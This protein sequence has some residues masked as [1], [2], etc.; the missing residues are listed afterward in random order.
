MQ[1]LD[2][3]YNS[4]YVNDMGQ[5]RDHPLNIKIIK[6]C[7][8]RQKYRRIKQGKK[9]NGVVTRKLDCYIFHLSFLI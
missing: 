4:T 8:S 2:S 3:A 5:A 1:I 7:D 6:K 9:Q